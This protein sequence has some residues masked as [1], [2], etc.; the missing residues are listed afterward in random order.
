MGFDHDARPVHRHLLCRCIGQPM[1]RAKSSKNAF[2]SLLREF[3]CLLAIFHAPGSGH[4]SQKWLPIAMSQ[5]VAMYDVGQHDIAR[6]GHVIAQMP[7]HL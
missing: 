4:I 1:P 5:I 3:D 2:I 6:V 7:S